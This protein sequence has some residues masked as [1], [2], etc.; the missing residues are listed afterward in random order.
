M[1]GASGIIVESGVEPPRRAS[2]RHPIYSSIVEGLSV[3]QCALIPLSAVE[4]DNLKYLQSSVGRVAFKAFG[5]KG[6]T[7]RLIRGE[8]PA[9]RVW[10]LA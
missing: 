8:D 3:G 9:V 5:S 4:T 10:R 7:T 2:G 1:A 6:Y